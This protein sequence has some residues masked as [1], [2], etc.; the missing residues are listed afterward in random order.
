VKPIY[1]NLRCVAVL[2]LLAAATPASA[3][4]RPYIDPLLRPLLERGVQ[5][6]IART[7]QL[8]LDVPRADQ[9]L[10]GALPLDRATPASPARVGTFVRLRDG[11]GLDELRAAGAE[12]G[13]VLGDIVTARIPVEALERLTD[14]RGITMIEA[15]RIVTVQHDSSMRAIRADVVRRLEGAN[16]TGATGRDAIVAIYDTGLDLLHLDFRDGAGATRVIGLW[17][18]T[19]GTGPAPAGRGY[20][21]YCSPADIAATIAGT[22]AACPQL[23][24]HGHGTHVAGSAA[25]NGAAAAEPNRYAGVAPEAQLLIVKGGNGSFSEDRIVDGIAWAR[26]AARAAGRPG[27]INLSLGGQFGPH[28][29]SRLYERAI[30]DLS[31]PGFVVVV[32]AGNSGANM[33][34]TPAPNTNPPLIH[35]RGLATPG[36][37]TQFAINISPYTPAGDPCNGN[38]ALISLWHDAATRL[39][40]TVVRPNG[41]QATAEHGDAI[42]DIAPTG[43]IY[44]DNARDGVN[45]ENNE[46]DILIQIAGCGGAGVPA[47]GDWQIRVTA[48]PMASGR[49][50]DMWMHTQAMGLDGL[51]TG[52][53]G[54][55]NRF[56]VGSPG[57]AAR[58]VTVGAFVTKVCWFAIVAGGCEG[59]RVGYLNRE[60][61]GDIARFSSP[62]PT[63][64]GRMKPEITAPG[65]AIMSSRS[66]DA[67]V[68]SNRTDPGGRHWVL[69]GT[70]MAAPHVTGAI[71]L[72]LEQRPD[73]TPEDVKEIF[74]RTSIQDAF[75][76]RSYGLAAWG[77]VPS[78]W[79]G[80][81]KLNVQD[82]LLSLAP[83][84]PVVTLRVTPARD[85][86]PQGATVRL[87]ADARGAQNQALFTR[88][89]WVSSNPAVATVDA[90]GL[91]RAVQPGNA[92]IIATAGTLAD[93]ALIT[94]TPPATLTIT[95]A[96]AAPD[97]VVLAPRGTRLPLLALR[98]EASPGEPI[99]V[100]TL[101][102]DVTGQDPGAR[103]L[104]FRDRDG[105]GTINAGDPIVGIATAPLA[106]TTQRV[107]IQPDTLRVRSGEPVHLVLAVEVSGAAPNLTPFRATLVPGETRTLGLRSGAVDRLTVPGGPVTSAPATTTLLGPGQL[108]SMS[109][110]PVRGAQL[111]FNF[112]EAPTTAAV[113]TLAGARVVDLVRL[114]D[115]TRVLW[116]LRN[117]A[118][119]RVAPGVYLLVFEVAGETFR[120]RLFILTPAAAPGQ[121]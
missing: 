119:T 62:G 43:Q 28:D 16:W 80:Y 38:F 106:G 88:V 65:I 81:G 5:A 48:G 12:I 77:G 35:A 29:G 26:D 53:I 69:E 118:G 56:I 58:A 120:E 111:V 114:V 34:L 9:P 20:G 50:Y 116:N 91:V 60:Q 57:N 90:T 117:D 63:R 67:Q 97:T 112:R 59:G 36:F 92:Y 45:P 47:A 68:P 87:I 121:E 4:E 6:E 113:Y 94:V 99:Q 96:S 84:V 108:F 19:A 46:Y 52:T 39:S 109:E 44:I 70:S 93:S 1:S 11:R 103:L 55:D 102:F 13:T 10:G 18:Q 51:V 110:N 82:G 7:P 14:A 21:R 71:A 100:L 66:A 15:A 37:T 32:S 74:A 115:G 17:D 89:T 105:A 22:A 30:D 40:V 72:F 24:F 23:D 25:G 98:L 31:G 101:S 8:G 85:T 41:T 95:S 49:P 3:Q 86:L 76:S 64:D 107:R 42:N 79:W 33:N 78:D 83:D 27:V 104:L 54:F 61:I 2:A 73:L 75:T